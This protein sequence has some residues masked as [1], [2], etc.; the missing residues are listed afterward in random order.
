MHPDVTSATPGICPICRMDLE[1]VASGGDAPPAI[2]RSTFQTYDFVRRRGF[3][4]DVRAPAWVDRDG[5]VM[6]IL[7]RDELAAM[8]HSTRAI[9]SS[10]A[11]PSASVE[12]RIALESAEPWD[13][14]TSR[15]RFEPVAADRAPAPDGI[16]W[17]RLADRREVHVVPSSAVLEGAE[18]P[19]VLVASP[20]GRTLAKRPIE[21]GRVF[22]GMAVVLSG[23]R[24]QE[25]VLVRGAF[26][27][28]A[29]RRLHR[30]T[31]VE[32][33]P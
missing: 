29:E 9:F 7:Y 22:G 30:E 1:P 26:F 18:G 12:V 25:R 3:A 14:A 28:D 16:G 32:L 15:V 13:A 19:Y 23:L 27:L 8:T 5:A 17:V 2:S 33:S 21:V 6:A 10:V 20:S 24:L 4:P 31:A 11:A